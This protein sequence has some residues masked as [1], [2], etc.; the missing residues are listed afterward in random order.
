[1]N[2]FGELAKSTINRAL[3]NTGPQLSFSIG[4]KAYPQPENSIWILHNGISKADK[5][6]I[7]VFIFEFKHHPKMIYLARNALKRLKTIR[8]PGIP[9]FIDGAE[10]ETSIIF[11]TQKLE[12]LLQNLPSANDN[13]LK[14]GL[15]N[16][17]STL[18]FLS[19]ECKL[20]HANVNMSSI[21]I[22]KSGEWMLGGIEFMGPPDP[23]TFKSHSNELR[24]QLLPPEFEKYITSDAISRLPVHVIDAW[25]FGVFV[26]VAF[27]NTQITTASLNNRGNIPQDLFK[28]VRGLFNLNPEMRITFEQFLGGLSSKGEYFDDK[29]IEAQNFLQNFAIQEKEAKEAFLR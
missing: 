26:H 14:L 19:Q 4:D 13:L 20:I 8:Y 15:Y 21:F 18:R 22:T 1:M 5:Q 25:L 29:L 9:R 27:K 16:I 11:G 7:T 17:A 3:G 28:Y 12:P 2:L 24:H 10:T 6:E 23:A